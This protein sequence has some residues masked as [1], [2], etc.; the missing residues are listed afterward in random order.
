MREPNRAGHATEADCAAVA[1]LS[2]VVVADPLGV[3][4]VGLKLH[5]PPVGNPV[6]AKLTCWL[7]PFAGVTV[8]VV[9]T[10][11]PAVTVPLAGESAMVKLGVTAVTV[12]T[13]AVD[14]DP[15]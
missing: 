1:I 5:E 8:M 9:C 14:V 3:T 13:T 7:K 10:D 15:E 6:Q 12:T 11:C 2:V 4:V